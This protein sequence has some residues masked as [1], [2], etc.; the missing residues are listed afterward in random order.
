M[1]WRELRRRWLRGG[2]AE[3]GA[4]GEGAAGVG[5]ADE[6][7]REWSPSAAEP[8][9][10]IN[11]GGHEGLPLTLTLTLTP[12]PTPTPTLALTLT[13]TLTLTRHEGLPSMLRRYARQVAHA[14]KLMASQYGV[15]VYVS[16]VR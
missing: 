15:G 8:L 9:L 3:R 7:G 12:T 14:R 11:C 13:R 16:R 2:S 10:Y 6:G 5:A 1:A 4:E